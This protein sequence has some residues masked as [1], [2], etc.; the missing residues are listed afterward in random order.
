[1]NRKERKPAPPHDKQPLAGTR[2]SAGESPPSQDDHGRKPER[3]GPKNNRAITPMESAA[4]FGRAQVT[5]ELLKKGRTEEAS[6]L[7]RTVEEGGGKS[8]TTDTQESTFLI[9]TPHQLAVTVGSSSEECFK[10]TALYFT[11]QF[12][13]LH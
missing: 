3:R 4:R 11:L 8:C 6:I 9:I 7:N 12:L 13:L 10:V 1:M 5:F 2:R